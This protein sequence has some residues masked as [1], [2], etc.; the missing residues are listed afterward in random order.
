MLSTSNYGAVVRSW[1]YRVITRCLGGKVCP[2]LPNRC[3]HT[4][5]WGPVHKF[6]VRHEAVSVIV[7]ASM[8]V[9]MQR[10]LLFHQQFPTRLCVESNL[11]VQSVGGQR[12][13]GL[14]VSASREAQSETASHRRRRCKGM[15]ST[16]E[17][18]KHC[19]KLVDISYP[20]FEN[21]QIN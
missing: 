17:S 21:N 9:K 18:G 7:P 8:V 1:Q 20:L 4:L 11:R 15:V 13:H 14:F 12:S 3:G 5:G 10:N 6:V 16:S 19:K 2:G